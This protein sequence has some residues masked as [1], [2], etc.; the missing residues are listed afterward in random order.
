MIFVVCCVI[1]FE[2]GGGFMY[3]KISKSIFLCNYYFM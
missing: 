1:F 3:L 2:Y